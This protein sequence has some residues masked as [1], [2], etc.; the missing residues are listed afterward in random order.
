MCLIQGAALVHVYTDGSVLLTSGGVEMGQGLYTKMLQVASRALQ[1]PIDKIHIN[2]TSSDTV[3]NATMTSGSTGTDLFGGAVLNACEIIRERID[4]FMRQNPSGSWED[5]VESAHLDRVSLSATG[6]YVPEGTVGYDFVTHTGNPYTY[7]TFGAACSHVEVDCITGNH[8]I[9][10]TDIMMDVGKS[11][12]PT[13]DIGQIE[14]AFVQGCGLLTLEELRYTADGFLC[15]RH[16]GNYK[17]PGVSDVPVEFNVAL[18]RNSEN[19]RA[20]YSSKAVGEPPLLLAST[21]FFAIKNAIGAAREQEGVS[22]SFQFDSPAT[23]ENILLACPS[24]LLP[25]TAGSRAS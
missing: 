10:R 15:T 11:L 19:P 20:I 2:E 21:V 25:S 5:W 8:V 22:G 9:L 1:I 17:I 12:N 18:L 24:T 14:G 6:F 13:I 23:V 7:H 3:P 4:P 16:T